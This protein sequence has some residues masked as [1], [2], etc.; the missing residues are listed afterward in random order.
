MQLQTQRPK[1]TKEA[2]SKLKGYLYGLLNDC[3]REQLKDLLRKC[4]EDGLEDSLEEY[5]ED[6]EV[7]VDGLYLKDFARTV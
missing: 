2:L 6:C 5:Y 4:L 1:K 7:L 3:L